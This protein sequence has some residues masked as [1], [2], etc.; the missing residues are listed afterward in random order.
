MTTTI[1]FHDV[2]YCYEKESDGNRKEKVCLVNI[3][4]ITNGTKG[5][6]LFGFE[7]SGEYDTITFKEK[8]AEYFKK[9]NGQKVNLNCDPDNKPCK[10]TE[11]LRKFLG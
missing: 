2:E 4:N 1:V 3:D 8:L 7:H 9:L 10:I 11:D 5:A 6:R